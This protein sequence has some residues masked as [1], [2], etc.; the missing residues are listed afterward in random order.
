MDAS[1]IPVQVAITVAGESITFDFTGSAPQVRG[2]I[3]VTVAGLQAC[4][5]YAMKVLLDPDCPQNHGMLDPVTI[6]APEGTIVNAAF[7]AASAAR[8][9]TGQRIV[10][11][12]FGALADALPDRIIAAGNGA[13]TSASFFG[14][15][16]DGRFYVYLET[17]GGGAGGRAYA[18]GTDGVQVHMTN[19]SNLP[20]E[21]LENE[22]PLLI[23][24]YELVRDSGGAGTWRGGMGIRRVYRAIDH[25]LTFSGQGERFVTPPWGLFGGDAGATGRFDVMS[26]SGE[27]QRLAS[28]PSALEITPQEVITVTTPGAGGYGEPGGRNRDRVIDDYRS[29]RFSADYLIRHYGDTGR[30]VVTEVGARLAARGKTK[31]G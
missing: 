13:N 27:S 10:D 3:N 12:I 24:R 6:R 21:A 1:L 7:P 9:Q 31:A 18:D 4:C 11:L 16:P 28:K 15:G 23:E 30:Q 5:L 14:R 19:T 17:L 26:D 22:Y 25:T 8:A 29:G 20:I 2:N